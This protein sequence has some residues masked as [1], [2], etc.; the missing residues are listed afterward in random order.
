[1]PCALPEVS[2]ASGAG[3]SIRPTDAV[4]AAR[5]RSLATTDGRTYWGRAVSISGLV[6]EYIVA[7]DVTRVRFPADAYG[8]IAD[9]LAARAQA[10]RE[11]LAAPVAVCKEPAQ[12]PPPLPRR[13]R[14]EFLAHGAYRPGGLRRGAP[15][16]HGLAAGGASPPHEMASR[17]MHGCRAQRPSVRVA[18][19]CA[20]RR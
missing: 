18:G 10:A 13:L 16:F 15:K 17:A 12:S 1:M 19:W 3:A 7:I 4:R 11:T 6:A 8:S 5:G 2:A 9:R 14:P 20:A